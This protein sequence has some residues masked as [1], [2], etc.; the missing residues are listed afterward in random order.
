MWAQKKS[1]NN[2][3]EPDET[4]RDKLE[5]INVKYFALERT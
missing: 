2:N 5:Y 3:L 1:L 4:K